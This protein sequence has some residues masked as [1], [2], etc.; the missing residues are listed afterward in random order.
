[1]AKRGRT[2]RKDKKRKARIRSSDSPAG[3]A[4]APV[5]RAPLWLRAMLPVAVGVCA[6]L[7]FLPA[8]DAGFVDWDDDKVIVNNPYIRGMTSEH[9]DWMFT[10]YKMGHFHPLT[11]LS[12]AVDHQI[13]QARRDVLDDESLKRYDR[14]LD[15][16]IFHGTNLLLH[17]GVAIGFYFL[18][19]LLLR[20]FLPPHR[21]KTD[22]A[23]PVCAAAAAVFFA[24]HPLRVETVA[25]ATERRDVLSSVFLIPSLLLYLRYALTPKWGAAKAALYVGSITLLGVSLLGKAWGMTLPAVMLVLD[26]YPLRRLGGQAGWLT[27]RA[28]VTLAEKLPFVALAIFFGYHA[29]EAQRSALNTAKTLEEWG[30]LDRIMQAFYGLY[31]YSQ[32]TFVPTGLS[33]LVEL[34][35]NNNPFA[36]YYLGAAL[37][38]LAAAGL[39]LNYRKRWPAGVV[40]AVCYAGVLTPVLGFHQSGPQLVADRYSY[41]ACMPWALILGAGLLWLAR[42]RDQIPWTR[43][44][45]AGASAA[46]VVVLAVFA[47]MTWRQT[48][49][50]RDSASLWTQALSVDSNNVMAH[51]N[52]GK[53]LREAGDVPAAIEHYEAALA[54]E[55]TNIFALNN[56]AYAITLDKSKPV[57]ERY[58]EALEYSSRAVE[59]EPGHP[60]IRYTHAK[61][62][63]QLDR[64]EEGVEQIRIATT[65]KAKYVK[66]YRGLGNAY[67]DR[68]RKTGDRSLLKSADKYYRVA[69]NLEREL[70]PT[71]KYV[72][73]ALDKLATIAELDRRYDQ[74]IGYYDQLL[75]IDHDNSLALKGKNRIAAKKVANL[76]ER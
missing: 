40:A 65:L 41:L 53:C 11:W 44:A 43:K 48:K 68:A 22:W 6:V 61:N 12:Y 33:P 67:L 14:G 37:V 55:P 24:C 5:S 9:V 51:N 36:I 49:T 26:V 42:Q 34:P 52:L 15:P 19:R 45:L 60:D 58:E 13:G 69:L 50:W 10:S 20:V 29:S 1:V 16:K 73:D 47:A 54:L 7:A 66:G 4:L 32:K 75:A 28:F 57:R 71:S 39:L 35:R 27:S 17:A 70:N 74:A 23:T 56:L 62:L 76:S 30:V 8:L 64:F 38:V 3:C 63:L 21:D 2:T 46:T 18:A 72:I 25:W 59:I 31:F